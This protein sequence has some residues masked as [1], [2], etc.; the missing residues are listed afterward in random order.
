MIRMWLKKNIKEKIQAKILWK[1]IKALIN[2]YLIISDEE[3]IKK[4]G[5]EN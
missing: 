5:R 2:P 3:F 1:S 4:H